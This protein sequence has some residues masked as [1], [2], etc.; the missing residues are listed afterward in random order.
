M[1]Y[2]YQQVRSR[3]VDETVRDHSGYQG[4][5]ARNDQSTCTNNVILQLFHC[6]FYTIVLIACSVVISHPKEEGFILVGAVFALG[7]ACSGITVALCITGTYVCTRSETGDGIAT[8][9]V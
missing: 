6:V 4:A 1:S 7:A 5:N 2:P 8:S 9:S 3:T